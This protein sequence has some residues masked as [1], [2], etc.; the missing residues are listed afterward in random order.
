MRRFLG[1]VMTA[2]AVAVPILFTSPQPAF[3]AVNVVLDNQYGTTFANGTRRT[4][5]ISSKKSH[6]DP[7][8]ASAL[9]HAGW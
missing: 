9:G 6:F 4:N 5:V 7:S 8:T 2:I 3:A 1:R